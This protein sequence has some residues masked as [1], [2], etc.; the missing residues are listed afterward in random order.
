[1][2]VR[3]QPRIPPPVFDVS[4][5]EHQERHE[6][7][8]EHLGNTLE[9]ASSTILYGLALPDLTPDIDKCMRFKDFIL[10]MAD[11]M[12][13]L[14]QLVTQQVDRPKT[15][16]HYHDKFR[17]SLCEQ[18]ND[19]S[20]VSCLGSGD[21]HPPCFWCQEQSGIIEAA[22][23]RVTISAAVQKEKVIIHNKNEQVQLPIRLNIL[24][25]M[26]MENSTKDIIPAKFNRNGNFVDKFLAI[27]LTLAD[28]DLNN[29]MSY[30]KETLSLNFKKFT[31]IK[32]MPC[33]GNAYCFEY[34]ESGVPHLHG[35]ARLSMDLLK[36]ASIS[37]SD[38]RF[39]GRN[40][41]LINGKV[42]SRRDDV[43]MLLKPDNA[44]R[45]INYLLKGITCHSEVFGE[46]SNV[47]SGWDYN[48]TLF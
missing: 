46:L 17:C 41:I 1:M 22:K 12:E 44:S 23:R 15:V 37:T 35:I 25:Q 42:E 14:K 32:D 47:I 34:H 16:C 5:G 39:K 40:T 11:N 43:K 18:A 4:P 31:S 21:E 13:R 33:L 48:P 30:L 28:T 10:T 19:T 27:T 45:W 7:A 26:N 3:K 20:L 6:L 8:M 9:T 29:N 24:G 38:R 36:Q 2:P